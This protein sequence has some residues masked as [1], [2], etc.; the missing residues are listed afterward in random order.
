M[1]RVQIPPKSHVFTVIIPIFDKNKNKQK[2]AGFGPYFLATYFGISCSK[3]LFCQGTRQ[4]EEEDQKWRRPLASIWSFTAR[5]GDEEEDEEV[6]LDF[7]HWTTLA[8]I[9]F[10]TMN[11]DACSACLASGLKFI[12]K[13]WGD[14]FKKDDAGLCYV[15]RRGM[16]ILARA[17]LLLFIIHVYLAAVGPD[18]GIF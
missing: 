6:L 4:E 18:W 9:P 12:S 7:F 15:G 8:G 17:M 16:F 13:A 5:V 2:E 3:T 14:R 1:I 10:S 11:N